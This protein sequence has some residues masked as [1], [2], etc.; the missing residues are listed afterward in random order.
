MEGLQL[1]FG[2]IVDSY[3]RAINLYS[4]V[5]DVLRTLHRDGTLIAAASRTG[6]VE[7]A[8]Q[9]L[10]L[11][12]LEQYFC[13]KE[14]YPGSKVTHFKRIKRATG[15][16]YHEMIFFDDEDRSI[17]EVGKLGVL[18]IL[19]P[20]GMTMKLLKEGLVKF[21]ELQKAQS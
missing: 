17:V 3:G 21:A 4:D 8:N 20:N 5:V 7:G 2:K 11:L 19:V 15:F 18:C 12:N 13:H 10:S 14:I 16:Q 9:L 1:R 6:E